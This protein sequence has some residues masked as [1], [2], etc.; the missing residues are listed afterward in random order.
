MKL[1]RLFTMLSLLSPLFGSA[2]EPLKVGD[3][4]PAVSAPTDEGAVLDLA[5]VYPQGMT[6]V[7]FYPKADTPGCT[8]QGCSLRDEYAALTDKGVRVIGVSTDTVE[9]QSRFRAKYHLPFTLLADHD[10]KVVEAFG[11]PTTMGF[12]SRQAYL[13]DKSGKV[14]W[15]DYKAKTKEQAADVLRVL[16][17]LGH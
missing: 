13:I 6:L 9:A 3:R 14:V 8:A 16:K 4:A 15:A 17:G 10:K 5:A 12:A 7:Y 11:V 2:A 1:L